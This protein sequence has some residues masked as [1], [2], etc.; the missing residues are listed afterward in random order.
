MHVTWHIELA[1]G[2][3]PAEAAV[4]AFFMMKRRGFEGLRFTV[5][6][7]SGAES[8]VDLEQYWTNAQ[9]MQQARLRARQETVYYL[10]AAFEPNGPA[11]QTS[12]A[13]ATRDAFH[14]AYTEALGRTPLDTRFFRVEINPFS[15]LVHGMGVR[16]ARP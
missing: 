4:E 16:V 1:E 15:I 14:A 10:A 5:R 8:S 11:F 13:L 2:Q 9:A 6:D 7:P 3:A 12:G